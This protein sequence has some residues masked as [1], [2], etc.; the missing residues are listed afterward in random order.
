L[1]CIGYMCA[2]IFELNNPTIHTLLLW[3]TVTT[4]YWKSSMNLCSWYTCSP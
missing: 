2:I 3:I 1:F 4:L